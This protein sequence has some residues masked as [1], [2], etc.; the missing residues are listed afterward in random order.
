MI[1]ASLLAIWG[2]Y[3]LLQPSP[4]K[5]FVEQSQE[6]ETAELEDF[7]VNTWQ[8]TINTSSLDNPYQPVYYQWISTNSLETQYL[9]SSP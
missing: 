8:G 1:A 7:M 5:Q 6:I 9:V 4:Y 2:G 3:N